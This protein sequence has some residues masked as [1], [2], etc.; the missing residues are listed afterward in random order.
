MQRI[1]AEPEAIERFLGSI[2]ESPMGEVRVPVRITNPFD[3][4][5]Y[6]EADFLVDT[7]STVSTVPVDVLNSIGLDAVDIVRV[8]MADGSSALRQI[9]YANFEVVGI[10]RQAEVVFGPENV[11]PLLGVTL[12]QSMGQVVDA[13]GERILP[14]SALIA[15]A[16]SRSLSGISSS[17]IVPASKLERY[18][19]RD[20]DT[21]RSRPTTQAD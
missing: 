4:D 21:G 10:R 20:P 18:R 13:L 5:R 11:E 8:F 16:D 3:A 15:S 17:A 1:V 9:C 14:R 2:K 12:L 7:C 19:A 6:W